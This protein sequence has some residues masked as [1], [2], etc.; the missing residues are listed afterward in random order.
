MS[1]DT[2]PIRAYFA[3]LGLEPEVA[4]LYLA[5]HA[6]GPQ[7]VSELSRHAGIE[8]TRTY[9]LLPALADAHLTETITRYKRT[10]ISAAPL[11]NL[12]VLLARK[13][14]ELKNLQTELHDVHRSLGAQGQ[15]DLKTKVQFFNG[16]EG[17][18]QMFWHQT[19]AKG[20]ALSILYESMQTRTNLAFFERWVRACNEQGLTFRS[21]I[22]DHFL[23]TIQQWYGEHSNERLTH[24]QARYVSAADYDI[25]HSMVTYD[26]VVAYYNWEDGE[27]FGIEIYNPEIASA[28][29][30]FFEMLWEKGHPVIND[31]K[32]KIV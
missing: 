21:I 22:G 3:K 5:L 24:W 8:R 12:Q 14:Q 20:E 2:S 16:L 13:E 10:I 25:T 32:G 6:Y 15:K 7:T 30:A 28:Q 18:K 11:T 4:D 9:R 1:S 19:K 17:N 26:D 29:R 31:L 23:E 27:A